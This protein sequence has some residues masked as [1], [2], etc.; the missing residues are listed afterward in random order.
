MAFP[1]TR[2]TLIQR[3][4][5]GGSDED[6]HRFLRDYWGP[7]CRFALRWGARNLDDAEEVASHT[8]AVIWENR[9]LGRW[10]S[11]RS[12]KLRSLLCAVVRNVLSNWNRMRAG[13][14]RMSE[15][16]VRGGLGPSR[17]ASA[18]CTG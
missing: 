7:I 4:A 12:A 15:E 1:Q 8:V 6:W 14:Q 18:F 10:M 17:K 5:S 9:L 3:L 13:R 2:L 11:N 16:L